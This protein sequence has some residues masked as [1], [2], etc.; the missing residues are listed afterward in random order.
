MPLIPVLWLCSFCRCGAV[1]LSE[2]TEALQ[3]EAQHDM[4]CI[5]LHWLT[6]AASKDRIGWVNDACESDCGGGD[7]F[8]SVQSV[9]Y[10]ILLSIF[11]LVVQ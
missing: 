6:C 7:A 10:Y 1:Q 8:I 3:R 4:M 9:P 11:A 5:P 2:Q